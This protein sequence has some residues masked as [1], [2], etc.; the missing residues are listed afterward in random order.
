[1]A[2]EDSS[3]NITHS[4]IVLIP[5]EEDEELSDDGLQFNFNLETFPDKIL[6]KNFAIL[7]SLSNQLLEGNE[8]SLEADGIYERV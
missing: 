8:I 7:D 5:Y 2:A 4:P 6:E 3:S 1:M